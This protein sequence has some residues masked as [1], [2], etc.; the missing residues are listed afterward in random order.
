MNNKQEWN[1]HQGYAVR[2]A[3]WIS[4]LYLLALFLSWITNI[5]KILDFA[6]ALMPAISVTF[7]AYFL[8]Y[9]FSYF[10]AQED[11]KEAKLK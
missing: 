7:I 5:P 9:Y 2:G 4:A 10:K 11:K 3:V 8:T 6:E 1:N